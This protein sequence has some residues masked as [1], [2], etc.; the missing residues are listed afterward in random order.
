M[1]L[2]ITAKME[3]ILFHHAHKLI[4]LS[5][6]TGTSTEYASLILSVNRA[7]WGEVSRSLRL[8]QVQNQESDIQLYCFYDGEILE[9][10]REAMSSVASSVAADF[11]NH[12][13]Y[14]HCIRIDYPNPLSYEKDRHVVFL[15]KE[16]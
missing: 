5:S 8:V 10:D 4:E 14:E 12:K 1:E 15:R 16:P 9:E 11:P 7:L 2:F 3:R 6:M 13:V